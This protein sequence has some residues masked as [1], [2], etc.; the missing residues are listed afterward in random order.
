MSGCEAM[1]LML[2]DAGLG[3][4]TLV[5]RALNLPLCMTQFPTEDSGTTGEPRVSHYQG[6]AGAV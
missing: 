2:R 4:C 1:A 3:G 6:Q 5:K